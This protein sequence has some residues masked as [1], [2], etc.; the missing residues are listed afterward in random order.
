M[1]LV[2]TSAPQNIAKPHLKAISMLGFSGVDLKLVQSGWSR[3][4][5]F[6]SAQL[7][8]AQPQEAR[9]LTSK[10]SSSHW[11]NTHRQDEQVGLTSMG[12]C[13]LRRPMRFSFDQT[14]T[15]TAAARYTCEP[16]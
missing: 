4:L 6:N 8:N 9:A 13:A 16:S 14:K 10:K 12:V 2:W 1:Y 3:G 15:T 11:L 5:L 7:S